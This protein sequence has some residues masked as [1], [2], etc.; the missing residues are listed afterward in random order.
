MIDRPRNH[1]KHYE[2]VYGGPP[3]KDCGCVLCVF[4]RT[5]RAYCPQC[6]NLGG[7][8][9]PACWGCGRGAWWSDD[10]VLAA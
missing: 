5:V 2:G 1:T 8:N 4:A 7:K 6:N 3:L 10:P 9:K